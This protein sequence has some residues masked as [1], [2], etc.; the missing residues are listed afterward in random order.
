MTTTMTAKRIFIVEDEAILLC[1]LEDIVFQLGFDH[2]GSATSLDEAMDFLASRAEI[3]LALLDLNLNGEPSDS[4][5]DHLL[6]LGVP[7]LFVSG[8]G[9]CGVAERFAECPVLQKPYDDQKLAAALEL[10]LSTRA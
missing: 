6:A 4:I 3:D 2:V 10:M 9:R 5:A 8:Y 7:V 1:D